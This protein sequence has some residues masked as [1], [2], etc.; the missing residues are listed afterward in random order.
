MCFV[1]CIHDDGV[2]DDGGGVAD[3]RGSDY[4][5]GSG[6]GAGESDVCGGGDVGR[7]WWWYCW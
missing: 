2:S 7:C 1:Y 4:D 6:H 3:D 5:G